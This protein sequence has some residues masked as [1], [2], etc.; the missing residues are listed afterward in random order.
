L[1]AVLEPMDWTEESVEGRSHVIVDTSRSGMINC[2][3]QNGIVSSNFFLFFHSFF[4]IRQ[5][6]E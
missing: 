4:G 6:K 5:N 3:T 1:K 2:D